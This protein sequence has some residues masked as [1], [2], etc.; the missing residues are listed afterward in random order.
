M[1]ERTIT[2]EEITQIE[3]ALITL[4]NKCCEVKDPGSGSFCANELWYRPGGFKEQLCSLVGWNALKLDDRLCSSQAYEI[5]YEKC[6]NALPA[7][8][9]CL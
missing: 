1:A 9:E 7:C 4:F 6:Y 3:P 8:R 2:W 5:A